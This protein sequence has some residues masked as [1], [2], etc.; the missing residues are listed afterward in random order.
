MIYTLKE[1][2]KKD[3][4]PEIIGYIQEQMTSLIG[5]KLTKNGLFELSC[6]T[7]NFINIDDKLN[8]L[9][10]IVVSCKSF[11]FSEKIFF[12]EILSSKNNDYLIE[13][14]L[15]L[16]TINYLYNLNNNSKII[17]FI[18]NER[19][20]NESLIP[21]GFVNSSGIMVKL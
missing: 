20:R 9:G 3:S 14:S 4:S 12:I 8:I 16:K 15:I 6:T 21:F 1:I 11:L 13:Q 10:V 5:Y 19:I 18:D 7:H 17:S 2:L